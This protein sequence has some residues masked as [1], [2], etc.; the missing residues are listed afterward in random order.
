MADVKWIKIV[1]DVFD[2]EKI[3]MIEALPEADSIIVIWFKLLCLAG[4]QNNSGVFLMGRMP[5]NDEMFATIFR[6]HLNTVRLAFEAFERYG[7]IEVINDTVTI[8]NWN[9]H[10]SLDSY[11]KKKERDRLYQRERRAAQ[12]AI[13]EKSSDKS[14]DIVV[15]DKIRK[16]IEEDIEEDNKIPPSETADNVSSEFKELWEIY[17]RKEGKKAALAS[18]QRAR[19]KG[20]TFE[21]VKSGIY[22]YLNYIKVKNIE[23]KYIKQGST[24][25]NGECWNDEY[26]YSTP[27]SS[28]TQKTSGNPFLDMLKNRE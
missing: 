12:K 11:E 28:P 1:T 16:E 15:S 25:F 3:L 17:P 27:E 20:A 8:P 7:M 14:S 23:P 19:K 21:D 10:Q 2:D 6:R 13:A 26:D 22:K 5:Y 9:K 4:K 18:Y 24:W